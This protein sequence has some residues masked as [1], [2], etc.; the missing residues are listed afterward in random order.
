[1]GMVNTAAPW[2]NG[3]PV[4]PMTM[5]LRQAMVAAAV[6]V[7]S[8]VP[9]TCV[10][11]DLTRVQMDFGMGRPLLPVLERLVALGEGRIVDERAS[12]VTTMLAQLTSRWMNRV[13]W[14]VW[15]T[16]SQWLWHFTLNDGVNVG[17]AASE[18]ILA[19]SELISSEM[20]E[21]LT[22]FL[23]LTASET[24]AMRSVLC[25][26]L[27]THSLNIGTSDP[28]KGCKCDGY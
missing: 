10:P 23:Q 15:L 6:V 18:Y 4:V 22:A 11:S 21:D 8:G 27:S 20:I 1:M 24:M 5:N 3:P 2:Y 13:G 12:T 26:S 28:T 14:I 9:L 16:H 25:I 19:R 7:E 17:A